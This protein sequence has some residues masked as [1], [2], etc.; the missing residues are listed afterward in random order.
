MNNHRIRDPYTVIVTNVQYK[1]TCKSLASC[2][3]KYGK[4][5]SVRMQ[6]PYAFVTFERAKSADKAIKS[7]EYVIASHLV[8]R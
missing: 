4:I 8:H 2:Y 6:R 3:E 5:S 1:E 7:D